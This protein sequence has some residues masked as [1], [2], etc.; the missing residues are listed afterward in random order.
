[1]KKAI[2][3]RFLAAAINFA[4]IILIVEKGGFNFLGEVATVKAIIGLICIGFTAGL[5]LAI[6][7]EIAFKN[8]NEAVYL[9]ILNAI[10]GAFV[11]LV[12]L[13]TTSLIYD[14]QILKWVFRNRQ[15]SPVG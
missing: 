8:N 9:V 4:I 6:T 14:F 2:F 3:I 10:L 11:L 5:P 15:Y 12:G 13:I 7:R 1:M